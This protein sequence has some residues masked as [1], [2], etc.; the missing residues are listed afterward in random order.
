MKSKQIVLLGIIFAVLVLGVCVKEL[1][2]PKELSVEEYAP[3]QFSFDTGVI[4][5]ILLS[6]AAEKSI[7]LVK[8]NGQWRI[9]GLWNA[10]ADEN[11]IQKF[12]AETRQAKGEVRS[13]D[14]S[15]LKDFGLGDDQALSVSLFEKSE[16][17]AVRFFIGGERAE[18]GFVFLKFENSDMVYLAQADLL[19]PM[20]VY[21]SLNEK[22]LSAESW[23]ALNPFPFE[24][25]QVTGLELKRVEKGKENV[26]VALEAVKEG[27]KKNWHSSK[28]DVP[29]KMASEKVEAFLFS[30]TNVQAAKVLDPKAS[31]FDAP[32]WQM[33]LTLEGGREILVKAKPEENE[34]EGASHVMMQISTEPVLF[35]IS[36]HYFETLDIEDKQF[37]PEEPAKPEQPKVS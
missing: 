31:G 34:G 36:K 30:L 24:P 23:A 26:T 27:D 19:T 28:K 2:K 20:K 12:L 5:K 16:K 8:E 1:Q 21:G 10:R 11:A 22:K 37:A 7:E 33:Q 14:S 17:P 13:S 32:V 9:P 15:L 3:L 35:Q 4:E 6:K 29:F 18:D 25:S